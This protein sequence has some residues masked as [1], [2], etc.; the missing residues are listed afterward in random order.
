MYGYATLSHITVPSVEIQRCNERLDDGS[1]SGPRELPGLGGPAVTP[2]STATPSRGRRLGEARVVEATDSEVSVR[3][4]GRSRH[5]REHK[6]PAAIANPRRA[7]TGGRISDRSIRSSPT[8]LARLPS[9]RSTRP[10]R[11][12]S[13][14]FDDDG[15]SGGRLN[16]YNCREQL[17]SVGRNERYRVELSQRLASRAT[18]QWGTRPGADAA[19]RPARQERRPD[20]RL[21][22]RST[23]TV[24]ER[25]RTTP[26]TTRIH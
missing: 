8:P 15:S 24:I 21:L 20:D 4:N 3:T 23:E 17:R 22:S 9:V 14:R 5:E 10:D 25:T 7:V 26:L 19:T 12:R 13:R 6:L 11:P 2:A 18:G 16:R 1:L